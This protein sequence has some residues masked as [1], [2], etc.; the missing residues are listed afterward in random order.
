[1]TMDSPRPSDTRENYDRGDVRLERDNNLNELW[2][3]YFTFANFAKHNLMHILLGAPWEEV[4]EFV[5]P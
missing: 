4:Y 1:M 5:S 3:K 2:L